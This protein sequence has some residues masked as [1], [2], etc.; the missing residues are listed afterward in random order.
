MAMK[1]KPVTGM[2]DITPRRDGDPRLRDPYDQRYLRNV[3][4]F[5]HR[6]TLRGAHREPLQQAGRRKRKTDL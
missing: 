4:I 6:D 2:K 3:W 1:K 5:F